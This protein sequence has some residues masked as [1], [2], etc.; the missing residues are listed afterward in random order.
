MLYF[1]GW[2][3]A[4]RL[5]CGL[6]PRAL[7]REFHGI[8]RC[9]LVGGETVLL[10]AR[11]GMVIVLNRRDVLVAEMSGDFIDLFLLGEIH[12]VKTPNP[13]GLVRRL[14]LAFAS[15]LWADSR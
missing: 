3:G 9:V 11:I 4:T 14:C 10:V 8:C 7:S 13:G 2:D 15:L 12:R 1:G 5:R 6:G